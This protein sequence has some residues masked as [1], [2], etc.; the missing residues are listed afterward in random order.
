[1][2]ETIKRIE[3]RIASAGSISEE[4][5]AELLGLIGEL[6]EEADGLPADASADEVR[7]ALGLA[8]IST[9]EIS[10]GDRDRESPLK[11][12]TFGALQTSIQELEASHPRLAEMIARMSHVLSRMGI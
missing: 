3:Q 12:Q 2:L 6:K 8:E 4:A 5:R 9:H 11:E 1:M 7:S 10:R